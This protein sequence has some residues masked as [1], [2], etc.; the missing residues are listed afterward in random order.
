ACKSGAENHP[1]DLD[2]GVRGKP[3]RRLARRE[4][5]GEETEFRARAARE[6]RITHLETAR[7][8]KD[9]SQIDVSETISP[10]WDNTGKIVGASKIAR[11]ITERKRAEEAVRRTEELYRQAITAAN[12][13]PYLSDYATSSYA[14]IGAGI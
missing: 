13:V 12:A 4:R 6:E 3:I 9:G 14:F 8:R 2:H 7:L 11:D 10:I 5:G 1:A